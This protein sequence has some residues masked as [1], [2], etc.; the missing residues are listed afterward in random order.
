MEEALK[1]AFR[2]IRENNLG[3]RQA[4]S[5]YKVPRA[6]IQD[7]IHSRVNETG[8]EPVLTTEGENQIAKWIVDIVK[9]GFP[10]EIADLVETVE[11]IIKDS[12]KKKQFLKTGNWDMYFNFFEKTPSDIN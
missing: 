10:L 12:E 1:Q 9:C 2:E 4:S 7:L 11:K 8:P 6:T 5:V 3:I